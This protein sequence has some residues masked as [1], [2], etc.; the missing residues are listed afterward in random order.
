MSQFDLYAA[1]YDL[2]YRDKDYGAEARYV[3]DLVK[4]LAPA[5]RSL[6][7]MGCGTGGHAVEFA[8]LGY[9][10]HGVDLSPAMIDRAQQRRATSAAMASR[11]SF[12]R[13]DVRKVR[14]G[15]RFDAAISLFHVVSYQTTTADLAAAFSTARAHLD[16]GGVFVFD[17]W[18]GPAVLTDRPRHIDKKA[19]DERICVHRRAR[20]EMHVNLNCVDVHFDVSIVARGANEQRDVIEV[21]RMRYL[22][23]PE[24]EHLLGAAGFERVDAQ[25][26]MTGRA[27]DDTTWYACVRA[28]AR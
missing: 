12:E 2:L 7:E 15:R 24:I 9:D 23:V 20:P 6:F 5:A 4:A 21:H 14:L 11:M 3:N 1:Y 27:L 18:Y 22:F 19:E 13:A 10:V 26:W 25:Q 28:V 8:H 17:C 16:V